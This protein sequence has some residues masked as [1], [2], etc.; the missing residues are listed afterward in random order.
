M[1]TKDTKGTKDTKVGTKDTKV[2]TTRRTRT[3]LRQ[4]YG[5]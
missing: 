2:Q 4:G 1:N 5:G 3:R